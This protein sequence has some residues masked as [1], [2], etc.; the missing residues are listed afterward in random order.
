MSIETLKKHVRILQSLAKKNK[1]KLPTYTWICANGYFYSYD[2]VRQAGLL[3][4][5][6][7]AR[8]R[9]KR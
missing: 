3:Y 2:M 7:R 1:G 4:R 6:D 5:F 9:R 8:K